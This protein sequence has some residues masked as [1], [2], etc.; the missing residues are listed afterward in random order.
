MSRLVV[1]VLVVGLAAC[2]MR[3][4]MRVNCERHLV[5]INRRVVQ[6]AGRHRGRGPGAGRHHE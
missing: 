5:R 2:S 4:P 6:P 1:L 3:Q